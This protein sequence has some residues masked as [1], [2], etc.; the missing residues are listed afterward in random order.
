MFLMSGG[1]LMYRWFN[2]K[3]SAIEQVLSTIRKL[4]VVKNLRVQLASCANAYCIALAVS[5]AL[6][7][8]SSWSV[9]IEADTDSQKFGRWLLFATAK[10]N[11]MLSHSSALASSPRPFS[12]ELLKGKLPSRPE[13]PFSDSNSGLSPPKAV[14]LSHLVCTWPPKTQTM[15]QL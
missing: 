11:P 13:K 5:W 4:Q 6:V 10:W 12:T 3:R 7:R 2:V 14:I 15:T 8:L 9:S 1:L